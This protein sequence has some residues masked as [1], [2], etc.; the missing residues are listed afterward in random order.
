M[1]NSRRDKILTE[2]NR[3]L[4]ENE[5]TAE[6]REAILDNIIRIH[7]DQMEDIEEIDLFQDRVNDMIDEYVEQHFEDTM[8]DNSYN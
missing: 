7:L 6:D 2:V 1:D 3:L 4:L 8:E 5:L